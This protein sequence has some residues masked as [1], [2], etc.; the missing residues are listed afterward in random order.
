MENDFQKGE[1]VIYTSEDGTVSLDAKLENETIWLTQKQMAELFGVKTP[2]ISKHLKNIFNEGELKEEVVISILETTTKHGAIKGKTQKSATKFYN[3]DAIISVGYRVNSSRATQ[4]RIWATDVLKKY[5]TQGYAL[6]NKMLKAQNA[7]IINLQQTISLLSRSIQNQIETVDDA[8]NVAKILD[9]FAKG[10]DLLDNFDH[11]TL[12]DK[13]CTQKPAVKISEK[14][15]L[16][17]IDKM[18]SEFA[19][20]VF[21]NPKDGSFA[22]SIN[23]IYQTFDG[24]DCYPTLEEKAAMLLYLITK[25][26]S[27]SDGNKRI[28]ASCFLY[29]LDKNNMLYKDNL[30]IIDSGT[31]FALT[32]LIAESNPEEMDVMKQI[33]V[34]VL[35]KI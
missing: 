25:N 7:K 17:I 29:F 19:S 26:H 24:K 14:E 27:F 28:A 3:L 23:Q 13:G 6:N 33:V 22:S 18:K 30:P 8:Q 34:S 16:N 15:Y 4:F 11:K 12:D 21:A 32:L 5:L 10:L 1:I 9:N 35:N 31:L 20:D 2:A